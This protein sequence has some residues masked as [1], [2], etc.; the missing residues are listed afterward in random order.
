MTPSGPLAAQDPAK[1]T[2]LSLLALST[3]IYPSSQLI[4]YFAASTRI[5]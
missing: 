4:S 3:Q 2:V 1:D 5:A